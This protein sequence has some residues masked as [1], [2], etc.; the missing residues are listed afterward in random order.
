[1]RK[2]ICDR[3][4]KEIIMEVNCHTVVLN[5]NGPII[6]TPTLNSNSK[7][8]YELCNSCIRYISRVICTPPDTQA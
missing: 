7:Y 2:I 8:T 4:E 5:V 1:M 3:C 6:N